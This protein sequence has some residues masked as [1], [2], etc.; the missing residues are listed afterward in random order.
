MAFTQTE[1]LISITTPLGADKLLLRSIRG[2]ERISGLFQFFLEMQ[3]EEKSLDFSKIVGKTAT[4]TMKLADGTKRYVNGIVGRFVQAG[5]DAKLTT[6]YA[7]LHPW[8]WLMTM[9]A[10]CRIWQNKSVKDIVTGLF[11]ELG[12]TDYKDSCT[13][14]YT[15]LE[16][17]V[18][19]NETAFAFVSRLLESAGIFYF[20]THED[21]KHTLVLGDDSS[22]F[23]DCAGAAKVQYGGH[24]NWKQQNVVSGCTIEE[25]VIPGKY[26]VDDFGFETPS[27]DLMGSSDSTVATNGSKRRIYEFPGG[28]DKKDAAEGLSKL[29]LEEREAPQKSLRGESFTPAFTAGG[30]TTLEKHYRDDVNAA[31]VLLR[32]SHAGTNDDYTNSFEAFPATLA[33]R[34][35]RVTRKPAIAG[36]QTAIVVGKSGEEIWTDKYGRV[37]VQFHWDQLGKND[38]N[39]SCWIRVAHGWAG[40]SWG[41]MFLPR[42]GQEVVVTFLNGDPDR[43][44]ITGSVYNAE[45]T[46]PYTLPADQTKSTI[47]SNVSKGGEGFNEIRFE[48]KKDSEEIFVQAQKDANVTIK[49]NETRK[50]GFDKKDKGN[51]TIDIYQD[52]TV[53]LDQGNDKLQVKT[54]NRTLLVDTGN[55]TYTVAGTRDVKVTKK[56][57]HTNEDEFVQKVTK[58][59]TLTIDGDLA[60]TVTGKVTF[61]STGDMLLQSTGKLDAKATGDLS[62]TGMN[63]TNKATTDL[64]NEAMNVTNKASVNLNNEGAMVASKASG[65]HNV[66]ASGILTVKGSLVKIN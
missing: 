36:T 54:G 42:I 19:Y 16:Y 65:M 26:A 7:E 30:K 2:E 56:E 6:Y 13:G 45:Q 23:A 32:V 40:K 1:Q 39:S 33:Y 47:K 28:F 18:Q 31:Y 48:D 10:D 34:P 55:D 4:V 64:K 11:T 60:I 25:M 12:F 24:G 57:T 9:S 35:P 63:I 52:R 3:S 49:N 15:A 37:K 8:F 58:N 27:T 44:L 59:Y 46:V 62:T 5:S 29:R 43:P 41:Q 66:E 17:C 53:T 22:A 38:E 14:T 51:Q 50:V 21:G 20:F 61:K